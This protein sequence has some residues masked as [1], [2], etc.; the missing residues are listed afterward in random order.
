[1]TVL[2]LL[3][4][5][6]GATIA[7]G[8][9]T[10]PTK[11]EQY[12]YNSSTKKWEKTGTSFCATFSDDGKL[13]KIT[14]ESE[15]VKT[16]TAYTWKGDYL[17]KIKYSQTETS[18]STATYTYKDGKPSKITGEDYT[19]T[20]K[21][22]GNKGKATRKDGDETFEYIH[23]LKNGRLYKVKSGGSKNLTTYSYYQSGLWKSNTQKYAGSKSRTTYGSNG[24]KKK[25]CGKSWSVTYRWKE[26]SV[27]IITKEHG[28]VT[29]KKKWKFSRTKSV[30]RAWNCDAYGTPATFDLY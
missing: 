17:K 27:T 24:F 4:M 28:K 21:W 30:S 19:T 29:S 26:N 12:R 16:T 15:S 18:P 6:T 10:V 5:G 1:M 23:I 9:V 20:F 8:N 13:R 7:W 2:F 11:G 14:F 3:I 25:D 22:K